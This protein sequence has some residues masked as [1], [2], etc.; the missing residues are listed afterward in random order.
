MTKD[1]EVKEGSEEMMQ[2]MISKSPL[3]IATEEKR[4][5]FLTISGLDVDAYYSFDAYQY[6]L[7]KRKAYTF[8]NISLT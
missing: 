7:I 4:S 2:C 3:L 1:L 6:R 8:L 5:L